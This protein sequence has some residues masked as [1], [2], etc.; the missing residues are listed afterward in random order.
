MEK[1]RIHMG[2]VSNRYGTDVTTII[3]DPVKPQYSYSMLISTLM[4][5][6]D[7]VPKD[8]NHSGRCEGFY[9]EG[10]EAYFDYDGYIDMDIPQ[11]IIDRIHAEK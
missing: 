7:F 10:V 1:I 2:R 4:R 5:N 6:L 8:E 11:S 9:D 3:D